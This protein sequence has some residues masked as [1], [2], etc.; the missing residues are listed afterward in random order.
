MEKAHKISVVIPVY[1]EEEN[2]KNTLL[3]IKKALEDSGYDWEIVVVDDASTDRTPEI[4]SELSQQINHL[5]VVRNERNRKLGYTLRRGF[6]LAEGDLIFYT[7]CDLPCMPSVIK[8]AVEIMD[9][10]NVDIVSAYRL[11]RTAEGWVRTL[12]SFVYN[13]LIRFVFG[14]RIK[15]IN[16]AC[17]LIKKKVLDSV[18]LESEGS[19]IDAELMVKAVRKGFKYMQ[20]G[21]DYFPRIKGRST[22]SSFPVILKILKELTRCRVK[23]WLGKE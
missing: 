8:Y 6:A 2:L 15:D 11:D 5:K 12:Y 19:F 13:L 3:H 14:V 16:F 20:F 1:N 23:L 10:Y 22:L 17:K 21:T 18:K 9:T 4:L 7:D